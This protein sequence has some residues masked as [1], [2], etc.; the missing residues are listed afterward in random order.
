M[1]MH[2]ALRRL[3]GVVPWLTNEDA[4]IPV[5]QVPPTALEEAAELVRLADTHGLIER[6]S[7]TWHAVAR[8]AANRIIELRA[9]PGNELN[10]ARIA[11]LFELLACD[12]RKEHGKVT[13]LEDQA[14]FIP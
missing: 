3:R 8:W 12:E 5:I 11:Q 7:P 14:P 9:R 1:S 4:P 13:V 2:E 10:D 6:Q